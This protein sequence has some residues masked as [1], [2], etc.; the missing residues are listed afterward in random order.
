V[1]PSEGDPTRVDVYAIAPTCPAGDFLA[2]A[3]VAKP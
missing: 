2:F 1:L 3:R